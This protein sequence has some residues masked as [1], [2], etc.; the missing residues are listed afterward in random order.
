MFFPFPYLI[1]PDPVSS[2]PGL[3]E[4]KD[5]MQSYM[6][7]NKTYGFRSISRETWGAHVVGRVDKELNLSPG[8]YEVQPQGARTIQLVLCVCVYY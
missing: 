6:K 2:Q 5:A 7:H 4:I 3:Y 8:Q 1:F